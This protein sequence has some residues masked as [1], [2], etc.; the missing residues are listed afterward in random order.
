MKNHFKKS[1][2]DS[3][4]TSLRNLP[5][6]DDK[7]PVLGRSTSA[8][9]GGVVV[10]GHGEA[11]GACAHDREKFPCSA[12]ELPVFGRKSPDSQMGRLHPQ[13]FS[14]FHLVNGLNPL[15][16]AVE[17]GP[18]EVIHGCIHDDEIFVL[19]SLVYRTLAT[20]T[21]ALPRSRGRVPGSGCSGYPQLFQ[22]GIGVITR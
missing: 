20:R 7:I 4:R 18:D 3:P 9:R 17:A 16:R 12:W 19:P 15:V 6:A 2:T 22:E 1:G 10:G 13:H 14:P 8:A 11:V 5:P 21:P